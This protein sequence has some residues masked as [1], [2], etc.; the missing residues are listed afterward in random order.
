[1]PVLNAARFAVEAHSIN[2]CITTAAAPLQLAAPSSLVLTFEADVV[3]AVQQQPGARLAGRGQLKACQAV[4]PL[5]MRG[6]GG[7]RCRLGAP[8]CLHTQG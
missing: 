1:M 8:A 7:L 3:L 4:P 6:L 2:N 5:G